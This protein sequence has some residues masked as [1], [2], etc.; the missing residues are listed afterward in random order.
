MACSNDST[1]GTQ[2]GNEFTLSGVAATGYAL[3]ESEVRF[4]SKNKVLATTYTDSLGRFNIDV[5]ESVLKLNKVYY[6]KTDSTVGA[7]FFLELDNQNDTIFVLMHPVGDY[8]A[9]LTDSMSEFKSG[10]DFKA[11]QDSVLSRLLGP[12]VKSEE[13]FHNRNFVAA[14]AMSQDEFSPWDLI[15][16]TV[17]DSA[18]RA[19]LPPHILMDEMSKNPSYLLSDSTWRNLLASQAGY[20]GMTEVELLTNLELWLDQDKSL[21]DLKNEIGDPHQRGYKDAVKDG[22]EGKNRF[23]FEG[24]LKSIET[25]HSFSDKP[26]IEENK[27]SL[28][29]SILGVWDLNKRNL[30]EPL[31]IDT[32]PFYMDFVDDL[33]SYIAN[34]YV[35]SFEIEMWQKPEFAE[36][37]K[38]LWDRNVN[39]LLKVGSF[40]DLP[41]GNEPNPTSIYWTTD[42]QTLME[43]FKNMDRGVIQS[44]INQIVAEYPVNP[45]GDSWS[46]KPR[47]DL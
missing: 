2:V 25:Q 14:K 40:K 27:L 45:F 47:L 38:E 43:A 7:P 35:T 36:V 39:P 9:S 46:P 11:W 17:S 23:L 22:Y 31:K 10:A 4:E 15:I 5:S 8:L 13:V 33:Q 21:Y 24:L 16:H 30:G 34:A 44:W 1:A 20:L 19:Q 18:R 32:T 41:V 3:S 28:E 12:G 42:Q 37:F 26:K 29:Q 6:L